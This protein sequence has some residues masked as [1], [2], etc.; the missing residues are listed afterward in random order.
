MKSDRDVG[1]TVKM[2]SHEIDRYI[3]S[4]ASAEVTR[5]HGWIIRYIF[6]AGETRDIFQRDIENVFNIRRSTA[7]GI[8]QLMEKNGLIVRTEATH[9]AR[10]KKITLTPKAEQI[11]ERIDRG[12]KQTEAHLTDGISENEL[13]S[14]F[15]IVNK[16]HE[17]LKNI[18]NSEKEEFTS[19][20]KN[21]HRV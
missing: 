19:C 6:V 10:M 3:M 7:T 5:M 21:C 20:L 12:I 16:M 18:P 1:H 9:D 17:N 8:L 13:D 2:L 4:H 14:F 15:A 11:R